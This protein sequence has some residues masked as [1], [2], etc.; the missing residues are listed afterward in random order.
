VTTTLPDMK[1][2]VSTAC[3]IALA[4][5]FI[6]INTTRLNNHEW[7]IALKNA[8]QIILRSADTNTAESINTL[9][10]Q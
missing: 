1:H 3:N 10:A 8:I 2:G 9:V 5:I 4:T 6:V 7:H